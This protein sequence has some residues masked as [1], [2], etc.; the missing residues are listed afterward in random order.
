MGKGGRE[1]GQRTLYNPRRTSMG[2]VWMTLSTTSG[3]GVKKSDD[4]ISGLKK[5]SGARNRSYPTSTLYFC[6]KRDMLVVISIVSI[7]GEE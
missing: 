4:M 1:K 7:A 2:L 5:I 3:S 6:S